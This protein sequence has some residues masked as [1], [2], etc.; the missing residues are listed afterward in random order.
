MSVFISELMGQA[1]QWWQADISTRTGMK[2]ST[3][4]V[5]EKAEPTVRKAEKKG[6]G[7]MRFKKQLVSPPDIEDT[8]KKSRVKPSIREILSQ[9]GGVLLI[10]AMFLAFAVAVVALLEQLFGF[11]WGETVDGTSRDSGSYHYCC[12][13]VAERSEK[14]G[15]VHASD[16]PVTVR[17]QLCSWR[18]SLCEDGRRGPRGSGDGVAVL[19]ARYSRSG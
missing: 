6:D 16:N 3:S 10:I 13:A 1:K 18:A 4:N 5:I 9:I 14:D 12:R 8:K 11:P 17:L 2:K 15:V 19:R 7:E